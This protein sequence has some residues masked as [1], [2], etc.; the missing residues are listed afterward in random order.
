MYATPIIYP[1][2]STSGKL[3]SFLMANPVTSLIENFRYGLFSQGEFLV[4]GLLYSLIFSVVL[5]VVGIIM[6]NQVEKNFM[7]TV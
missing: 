2:S 5:A 7:D 1:L 6:F 4:G 3:K